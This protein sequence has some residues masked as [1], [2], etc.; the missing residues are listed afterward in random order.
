MTDFVTIEKYVPV[1]ENNGMRGG[2]RYPFS[3]MEVGDSFTLGESYYKRVRSAAST[4]SKRHPEYKF[5]ARMDDSGETFR[6]WR[7]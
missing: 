5:V 7:V 2:G 6:I 4:F 3:K 1:P